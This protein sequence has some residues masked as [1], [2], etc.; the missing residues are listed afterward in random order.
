MTTSTR[1][2][3][4]QY[5][6]LWMADLERCT[7]VLAGNLIADVPT[8]P[9]WT[10][11]DLVDHLAGVY[12]HK[13][14]L[15][16]RGKFP[17]RVETAAFQED[18]RSHPDRLWRAAHELVSVL[19]SRRDDAPV[20]TFMTDDQTIGFWWRRMALETAV[21][22][23]DCEVAVGARTPVAAALAVDGIDELLWFATAPWSRV[24]DRTSWEGQQITVDAGAMQW[25][26]AL[27]PDGLSVGMPAPSPDASI[28]GSPDALLQWAAGR[29]VD[30]LDR[31]GTRSLLKE[32]EEQLRGF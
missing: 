25:G 6:D 24:G 17:S 12:E 18:R 16:E 2:T 21:H 15:L 30:D 8:C 13:I 22:R 7:E 32:L 26:V 1:L 23:T 3:T 19:S 5:R 4:A 31:S 27:T 29:R 14:L 10:V 20:P 9:G 11:A 28:V